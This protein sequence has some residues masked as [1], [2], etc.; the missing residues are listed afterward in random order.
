M[1]TTAVIKESQIVS[2][3]ISA[4]PA[5]GDAYPF[6]Y[7]NRIGNNDVAMYVLEA[8]TETDQATDKQGR[9][10]V[11]D[12]GAKS[13]SV[14]IYNTDNVAVIENMPYTRFVPRLN[15]GKNVYIDPVKID[16][17]ACKIFLNAASNLSANEVGLFN[18]I[19]TKDRF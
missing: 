6:E 19:F 9:T 10:L 7:N 12:D 2:A 11:S 16:L 13:L 5:A 15:N 4:T 8:Y 18:I 14:T 3:E 17:R 1:D